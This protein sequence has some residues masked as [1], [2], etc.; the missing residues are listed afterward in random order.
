MRHELDPQDAEKWN[1]NIHY[2]DVVLDEL[3]PRRRYALDIGCGEGILTRQLATRFDHV[4]G[5]DP[6]APSI[7][8]A[9][10]LTTADNVRYVID[11]FMTMELEPEHFDLVAS[12]V[13]IHHMDVEAAL[14]RM[15]AATRPGGRVVAVTVSAPSYIRDLPR[16]GVAFVVNN[17]RTV[18]GHRYEHSAP[19]VW[20]PPY[21]ATELAEVAA[22]VLP[23]STFTRHWLNRETIVWHK[24]EG[25]GS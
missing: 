9:E 22:R 15:A 16:L 6:D 19:V 20:P 3:P 4:L 11:D 18:T 13:V 24:P 14:E 25:S 21:T 2:H 5:V 10:D 1:A 23:G 7:T 8:T 12:V 17:A